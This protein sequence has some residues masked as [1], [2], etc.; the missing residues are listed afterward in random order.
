M[1]QT[2][3]SFSPINS[4]IP[5]YEGAL[6]PEEPYLFSFRAASP[7]FYDND[8]YSYFINHTENKI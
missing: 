7:I 3:I 8:G 2:E 1:E 4:F 6:R 5:K